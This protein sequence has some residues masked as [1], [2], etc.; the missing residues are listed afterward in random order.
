MSFQLRELENL[1]LLLKPLE[2]Y[3]HRPKQRAESFDKQIKGDG[4]F[5]LVV[6]HLGLIVTLVRIPDPACA[7]QHKK[8][9]LSSH[10][11]SDR[12][13][14]PKEATTKTTPKNSPGGL[15][16]NQASFQ[17]RQC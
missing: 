12:N 13:L 14:H 1:P 2:I 5:V 16:Y 11:V 9:L 17:L 10:G 8:R 7:G 6:S 4:F 15:H 3:K